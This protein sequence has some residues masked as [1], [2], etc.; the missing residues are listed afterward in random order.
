MN[1]KIE[2]LI[3]LNIL[4]LD[5]SNMKQDGVYIGKFYINGIML[6]FYSLDFCKIDI[7]LFANNTRK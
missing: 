3:I 7:C 2:K 1:T 4:L 5:K 6:N